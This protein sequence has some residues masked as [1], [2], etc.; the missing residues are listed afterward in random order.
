MS[1]KVEIQAKELVPADDASQGL[2]CSISDVAAIF[3]DLISPYPT[4]LKRVNIDLLF[5]GQSPPWS[6]ALRALRGSDDNNGFCA[7]KLT[8][9]GPPSVNW[10]AGGLVVEKEL[11]L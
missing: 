2:T 10:S 11:P 4:L 8:D 5:I 9:T 1:Q 6:N 3:G 7:G